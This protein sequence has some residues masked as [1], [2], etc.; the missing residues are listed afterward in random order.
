[1]ASYS[2]STEP[3]HAES[4][5][6]FYG[7]AFGS[8]S[9]TT[10]GAGAAVPPSSAFPVS[11]A[12]RNYM[13]DTSFEPYRREA[14]RHK[15]IEASRQSLH[16]TNV[17]DDGTVSTEGLWRREARDWSDGSGQIYFDRKAAVDSRF[18]HSR[19]V[20]P[21]QQWNLTLLDDVQQQFAS[22]N[23]NTKAI[24][25][26]NYVYIADGNKLTYQNSW[27]GTPTTVQNV[28]P[29]LDVCTNGY[30]VFW[31]TK[32]GVFQASAGSTTIITIVA[33]SDTSGVNT[34]GG[35]THPWTA[36]NSAFPLSAKLGYVGERLILVLNN[37]AQWDST[38]NSTNAGC[39]VFDLSYHILE[40]TN[41]VGTVSGTTYTFTGQTNYVVN[42]QVNIFSP[43]WALFGAVNNTV[44]ATITAVA[45]DTSAGNAAPYFTVTITGTAPSGTGYNITAIATNGTKLP[46]AQG[47]E[48]IFT[49]PN[50]NWV[51]TA[52]T[53][54]NAMIYLAG[55]PIDTSGSTP[56]ASGP[57]IVYRT[58]ITSTSATNNPTAQ[59]LSYPVQALPMPVGEWP[60]S[61]YCYLNFIFVGSNKGIRMAQTINAYD[62][63]GNAGDLKAGPLIP[64]ISE[65]P[66]AP[67]TA[68][69]GDDRYIYWAWNNYSPNT[70]SPY[71]TTATTGLGRLDL[72]NF[73]EDLGP[74]YATDLMVLGYGPASGCLNW[75]DWD[76]ITNTPL[77]SFTNLTLQASQLTA[78]VEG[79]TTPTGSGSIT[80]TASNVTVRS[81]L[82]FSYLGGTAVIGSTTFT[83]TGISNTQLL[84]CKVASGTLSYTSSSN[85]IGTTMIFTGYNN[86]MAGNSVTVTNSTDSVLDGTYTISVANQAGFT[87][88]N[89]SSTLNGNLGKNAVATDIVAT[90]SGYVFTGNP[91]NC[92]P[93]GYVDSGL[94]TFGIPDNKNAVVIDLNVE[95]IQGNNSGVLSNSNVAVSIAVDNGALQQVANYSGSQ[96]KASLNFLGS[97]FDNP[98]QIFGEQYQT[99][100]TLNAAQVNNPY[101]SQSPTLNRW[102]LKALPGI[103]SGILIS[104]VLLLSL[105]TVDGQQVAFNP[106]DEYAF[107]EGLRQSQ[108]IVTYVEGPFKAQVTVD[109]LDW[110]PERLRPVSQG[111][112]YGDIVVYLKTI[113]G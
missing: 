9:A 3:F 48:W 59:Y 62:P 87:V 44:T 97:T 5:P 39:N 22:T 2:A 79:N 43:S 10:S 90:N 38:V 92:V 91:N 109:Q 21:W 94:I 106:Y 41:L 56:V 24:A 14:F 27:S 82:G 32:Y 103:P 70:W 15:S 11:I 83:Y 53:A 111:G 35:T 1:M 36:A 51:M 86:F 112:Y 46:T 71:D 34:S 89:V 16:F 68:I 95:N 81:T 65:V 12:G 61:M 7:I 60:T 98:K 107:L 55:H 52:L 85:I 101:T 58:G 19:G 33:S 63:T 50:P 80:T 66:N 108:E 69:T 72:T 78:E 47:N 100:I 42:Q 6:L 37:L 57:G 113:A 40:A 84:G 25:V 74:A 105:D 18:A 8:T 4:Y 64:D 23:G 110:L 67:V 17:P 45:T 76:P 54:G 31:V 28:A 96:P 99:I 20:N 13:I 104:A 88:N 30:Y 102:A 26:G 29:I 75:L 49:H 93:S 73:I 77:M